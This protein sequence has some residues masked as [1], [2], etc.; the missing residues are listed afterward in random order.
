MAWR[1]DEALVRGEV[2]NR[3]RGRVT[4]RLWFVGREEPVVLDLVGNAWRDLAGQLLRFTNPEPKAVDLGGF[5]ALQRGSTGDITASRKVKVPECTM[6]EL[7]EYYEARK[8]FP[9]HWGNSLYLEWNSE[10]NGRVV[11]ES[12][13]YVLELD[14]EPTWTMTE[15]EESAQ[16]TTNGE[17][18]MG[19]LARM[20]ETLEEADDDDMPA[21]EAEAD[22]DAA[23][24]DLLLDRVMAR[25]ER[26]QLA[27]EELTRVL[28]EERTRLRRERG[29]PEPE[30][31]TPEQEAEQARRNEEMNAAGE[32]ALAAAEA[33]DWK[34]DAPD[35]DQP[36]VARCIVLRERVHK[37]CEANGWLKDDTPQE[38]PLNELSLGVMIAG[39][40]LAGALNG[41]DDDEWPPD[42][43]IAGNTLVRL[44]KA[45]GHLRDALAGIDAATEQGLAESGWRKAVRA[46]TEE[47]LQEVER[48]IAEVR[49]ILA[50]ED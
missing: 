42:R 21:S 14:T 25:M 37:D 1:I 33:D 24:M 22:A 41:A 18:A 31:P 50:H 17:A 43:L 35:R 27:P 9:W 2:D 44:K 48:L 23:R 3:V 13:N 7:M 32:E 45:R 30:L 12:A 40:K 36:L 47:I 29:E 6:D 34:H 49:A 28:E 46:E 38:H 4:G 10:R 15:A 11:I 39:A 19:S 16:R 26:E 5:A 8:P 20:A